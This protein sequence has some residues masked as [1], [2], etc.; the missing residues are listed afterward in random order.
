MANRI[1]PKL[2]QKNIHIHANRVP[3]TFKTWVYSR[4]TQ[5]KVFEYIY[6]DY[7]R[8]FGPWLSL[9]YYPYGPNITISFYSLGR[10]TYPCQRRPPYIL[11]AIPTENLS[12]GYHGGHSIIFLTTATPASSLRYPVPLSNVTERSLHRG[13]KSAQLLDQ[14]A[15]SVGS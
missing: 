1:I 10:V 8:I 3:N 13:Y 11:P 7:V 15:E 12:S 4:I 14:E 2:Q 5:Y 9:L 6:I